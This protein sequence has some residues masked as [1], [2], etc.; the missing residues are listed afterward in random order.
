MLTPF[1]NPELERKPPPEVRIVDVHVEPW[2]DG[3]RVRV[4]LELIPFQE[5][6]NIDL[7]IVGT[8]GQPAGS[9][10]IVESLTFKLVITMHLRQPDPA[11]KYVLHAAVSYPEL[12]TVSEADAEFEA[13]P[14]QPEP[15][16]PDRP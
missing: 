15:G 11:G 6:P 12:G 13:H 8:T 3:R 16:D 14:V 5:K 4:H 2:P 9:A 1:D 7:E 10:A